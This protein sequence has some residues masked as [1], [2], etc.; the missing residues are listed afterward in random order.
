MIVKKAE[1]DALFETILRSIIEHTPTEEIISD[2]RDGFTIVLDNSTSG[3][4]QYQDS[5]LFY[6]QK[7]ATRDSANDTPDRYSPVFSHA[8]KP[9]QEKRAG[10]TVKKAEAKALKQIPEQIRRMAKMYQPGD[11]SFRQE[12]KNFYVQGKFMEDYEDSVPWNGEIHEYWQTYQKCTL[13]QLRGYFTWRTELRKGNYQK[14]CN[15]FALMYFSE[16]VNGIGTASA[17]DSFAKI[18]EFEKNYINAGLSSKYMQY[19]IRQWMFDFAVINGFSPEIVYQYADREMLELDAKTEILRKPEQYSDQEVF[20]ALCFFNGKKIDASIVIQKD[21][22]AGISLFAAVWRQASAQY[23]QGNKNLFGFCFGRK[24]AQYW[25]PLNN[26]LYYSRENEKTVSYELNSCRKYSCTKGR[27]Y[28]HSY[29]KWYDGH[30]HIQE[31]IHEA[32]RRFRLY[33]K[34]GRPLKEQKDEAWAVPYIEAV[35]EADKQARLEAARPKITIDFSG[36]DKIRQDALETQGSLLTEEDTHGTAEIAAKHTA[37]IPSVQKE[38]TKISRKSTEVS[39]A[40][41]SSTVDKS[42]KPILCPDAALPTASIPAGLSI[43][44]GAAKTSPAA[45]MISESLPLDSSQIELLRMLLRGEPVQNLITAQ[46]GMPSVIADSINEAL[47]DRIGDTVVE[48]NG[49]TITLV[50]DYR[51][52]VIGIVGES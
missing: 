11:G 51:D 27:W 41:T 50:E 49:E 18:Q 26:T 22:E 8:V 6:G 9:V 39:A 15:A 3:H 14:H 2:V 44:S 10:K 21:K 30:R 20:D 25:Y 17:E 5:P 23:R 28:E 24:Y 43:L 37:I 36:L 19:N 46:H 33:L 40:C 32:D 29:R 31:L 1:L 48:C 42:G 34:T 38:R 7:L 12:L 47:F 4:V 13:A 52:E 16:L 45:A 35:I